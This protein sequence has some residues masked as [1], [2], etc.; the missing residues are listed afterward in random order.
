VPVERQ[1]K[2]QLKFLI[3]SRSKCGFNGYPF[4]RSSFI[5]ITLEWN[6]EFAIAQNMKAMN[7][8]ILWRRSLENNN[9]DN[10]NR[11]KNEN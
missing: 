7:L 1:L 9:N 4:H 6:F 2:I 3:I 10:N 8:K 11:K 5:D